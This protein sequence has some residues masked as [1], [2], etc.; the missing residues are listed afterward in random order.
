M[1]NNGVLT[2]DIQSPTW[3]G[4]WPRELK[5]RCR[6]QGRVNGWVGS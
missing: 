1:R 3:V 5:A 6:G 2:Y 4:W